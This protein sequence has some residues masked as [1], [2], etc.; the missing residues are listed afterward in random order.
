VVFTKLVRPC[1]SRVS[2]LPG[3]LDHVCPAH[4]LTGIEVEDQT[5]R[6]FEVIDS[7]VPGVNLEDPHLDEADQAR[8]VIDDQVF[9]G[10]GLLAD[11]RA[12]QRFRRPAAGML[13]KEAG[14]T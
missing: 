14:A 8:Q 3:R 1:P 7:G 9:V 12:A 11:P 6:L 13:L 10:L 5:I 4:P 2:R